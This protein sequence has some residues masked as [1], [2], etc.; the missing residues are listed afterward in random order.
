MLNLPTPTDEG[1][2][3]AEAAS[4]TRTETPG[5][6]E[7]VDGRVEACDSDSGSGVT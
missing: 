1:P 4:T 6:R 7:P 3:R 2:A 5:A